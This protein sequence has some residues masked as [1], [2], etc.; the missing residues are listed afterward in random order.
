MASS[1]K[2]ADLYPFVVLAVLGILA[3]YTPSFPGR[4][5]NLAHLKEAFDVNGASSIHPQPLSG[6]A[7]TSGRLLEGR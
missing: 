3:N 4:S 6:P 1:G 7:S 5:L 2:G